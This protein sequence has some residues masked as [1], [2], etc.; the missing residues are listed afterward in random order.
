LAYEEMQENK[1]EGSAV[2]EDNP[3]RSGDL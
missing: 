1:V 3:V 2:E